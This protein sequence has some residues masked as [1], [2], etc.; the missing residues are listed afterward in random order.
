MIS[1]TIRRRGGIA[2]L[3][4]GH[5]LTLIRES[6]GCIAWFGT[7]ELACKWWIDRA[8]KQGNGSVAKSDLHPL[9][10]ALSGA[11]AG[12]AFNGSLYPA[13][14]VKS[15]IQTRQG[16]DGSTASFG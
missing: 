13:D 6:F 5:S 14:L 8:K 7:Y 15:I 11:L 16:L 1:S 9:K 2:G 4:K 3:Y 12:M 10:L